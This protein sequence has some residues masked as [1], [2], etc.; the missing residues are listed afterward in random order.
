MHLDVDLFCKILSFWEGKKVQLHNIAILIN[1]GGC[2]VITL[3]ET[4]RNK[5]KKSWLSK[6]KF[7]S[8][9]KIKR[10]RKEKSL[11]DGLLTSGNNHEFH[12]AKRE[13]VG[14][15]LSLKFYCLTQTRV[16]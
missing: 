5:E 6:G 13:L 7:S 12:W 9:K 3:Y 14:L 4:K 8:L 11:F 16:L 10:K 1:F 15:S 2:D